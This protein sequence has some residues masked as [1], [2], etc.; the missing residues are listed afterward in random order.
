MTKSEM[1]V[2]L[3]YPSAISWMWNYCTY[4]GPFTDSTGRNFDLG[5]VKLDG[6]GGM[7]SAAIVD[8]NNPG[9]YR[10]GDLRVMARDNSVHDEPYQE[11]KKRLI[12]L[13]FTSNTWD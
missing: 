1:I 11:L 13:G 9:D 2:K 8:G 4:V 6:M 10:S 7:V 5:Y 12:S 3:H